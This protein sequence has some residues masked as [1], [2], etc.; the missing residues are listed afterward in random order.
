MRTLIAGLLT[1]T[2][3]LIPAT[4][5][6][7]DTPPVQ[8]FSVATALPPGENGRVTVADQARG[9]VTGDYGP[10]TEDQRVLYWDGRYKDG[11]FQA[12]GTPEAVGT[13][14]LM[15]TTAS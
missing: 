3:L 11:R 7:A 14:R 2:L 8:P 5:Y 6:A 10:H 12:T 13:Q 9:E 4:A 1:G 15:M